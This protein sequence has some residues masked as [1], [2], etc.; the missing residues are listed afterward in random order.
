M[1]TFPPNS[2]LHYSILFDVAGMA[3]DNAGSNANVQ[4]VV[5]ISPD[6]S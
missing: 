1:D 5:V 2:K 3:V 6:Y 4:I